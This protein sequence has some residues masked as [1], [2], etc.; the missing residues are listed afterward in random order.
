[1]LAKPIKTMVDGVRTKMMV[2]YQ[3]IRTKTETCRWDIT[4]TY[5]E[6]LEESKKYS[7]YYKLDCVGPRLWQVMSGEIIIVST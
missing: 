2:K 7:R 3:A 4:A 1:M 5:F 6:K